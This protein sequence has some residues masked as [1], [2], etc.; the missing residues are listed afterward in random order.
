MIPAQIT[1][2]GFVKRQRRR[3][4][5]THLLQLYSQKQSLSILV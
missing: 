1:T 5:I 4:I 3:S 2:F